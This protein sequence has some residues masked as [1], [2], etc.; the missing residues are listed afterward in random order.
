ML[1]YDIRV[2]KIAI[3]VLYNTKIAIFAV[4]IKS[5]S[6]YDGLDFKHV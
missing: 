4:E 6:H 3:N 2:K 1:F 5:E